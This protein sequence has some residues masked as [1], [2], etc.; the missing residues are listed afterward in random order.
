MNKELMNHA[1]NRLLAYGLKNHLIGE[2]D[3]IYCANQLIDLLGCD[4][5][6]YEAIDENAPVSEILN[7][8]LDLLVDEGKLENTI[9]ARDLMDTRIM[10]FLVD[11]PSQV[12]KKF[13]SFER[14]TQSTDY[15][16]DLSI[17]SNY[18]R[19]DRVNKNVHFLT[20]SEFGDIEVSINLSKPEKDPAEIK[21]ALAQKTSAYPKCVLC[22]ENLGFAGNLS[23]DSRKT[24]RIIPIQ[25]NGEDYFLQYSPYVYYNEHAIIFNKAHIPMVIDDKVIGKLVDFVEQLPHY[26]IGSNADLPIVGGSILSHDHFQGGRHVFPMDKA[27]AF[28]SL[29]KGDVHLALL[30]WPLSTVRLSSKDRHAVVALANQIRAKWTDYSD[31]SVDILSHSNGERHNTITPIVRKVG[32]EYIVNVVLRNNRTSSAYPDGIFHPHKE[33]HHVKKENIGLIEVMGL[34]ILPARLVQSA[35]KIVDVV[36]DGAAISEDIQMHQAIIDNLK[37]KTI[38]IEEVYQE[39]GKVFKDGLIDCGVF[40]LDETG[41]AAFIRFIESVI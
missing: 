9:T 12:V 22:E 35:Q 34:A 3:V 10:S 41:K 26:F 30:H 38:S 27:Q 31:E 20:P 29:Q 8:I 24:I 1:V 11:F 18:I 7:T 32:D 5:F 28:H 2:L 39:Y 19:M 15:F 40:K 4:E 14:V 25:L 23:R 21:K 17:K 36:N 6:H 13:H 33:K 37:G 16:Y